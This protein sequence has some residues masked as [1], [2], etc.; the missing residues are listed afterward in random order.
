MEPNRYNSS[1]IQGGI[2]LTYL[3]IQN[4]LKIIMKIYNWY[5]ISITT[6][7]EKG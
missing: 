4:F 5:Y 2:L 3:T 1:V 6:K 7:K